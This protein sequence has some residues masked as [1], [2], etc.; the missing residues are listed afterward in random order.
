[1]DRSDYLKGMVSE[2]ERARASKQQKAVSRNM[3]R[4]HVREPNKKVDRR[5]TEHRNM[6]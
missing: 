6:K 1:M 4:T 2:S 3:K 5:K